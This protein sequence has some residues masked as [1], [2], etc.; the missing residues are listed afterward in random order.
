MP[1]P[2]SIATG[3]LSIVG[4]SIK[5][6]QTIDGYASKYANADVD[7]AALRNECA[8]V[9]LALLQIQLVQSRPRVETRTNGAISAEI[10]EDYDNVLGSCATIFSVLH[11]RLKSF[12]LQALQK[13]NKATA[14]AKL[15]YTWNEQ[16]IEIL[17]TN[18]RGLVSA[19]S[20]LLTALQR[21]WDSGSSFDMLI[22]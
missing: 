1:D 19:L 21:Y 14:G 17:R 8:T 4:N 12:N 6:I 9:R 15:K 7:I 10:R 16:Q 3:V 11:E 5:A 2:L 22:A 13:V 18:I 20:L